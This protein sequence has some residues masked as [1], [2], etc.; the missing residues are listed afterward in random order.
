MKKPDICSKC[1]RLKLTPEI[2]KAVDWFESEEVLGLE[3][4]CSEKD[5]LTCLRLQLSIINNNKKK[6]LNNE[7]HAGNGNTD[8]ASYRKHRGPMQERPNGCYPE[9]DR[10]ERKNGLA[11]TGTVGG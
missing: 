1:G 9:K 3:K 4:Y 7:F 5:D 6:G 2:V 11:R 8:H 10:G